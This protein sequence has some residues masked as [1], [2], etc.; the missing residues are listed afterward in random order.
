MI[1]G[2]STYNALRQRLQLSSN[3]LSNS[4]FKILKIQNKKTQF[5]KIKL[6]LNKKFNEFNRLLK[7]N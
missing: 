1:S 4:I 3:Y 6:I 2:L 7:N 5:Q